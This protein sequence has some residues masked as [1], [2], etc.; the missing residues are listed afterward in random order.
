MEKEF[1]K[2][3]S[4]PGYIFNL[5]S[6]KECLNKLPNTKNLKILR[7]IGKIEKNCIQNSIKV[8]KSKS[9]TYLKIIKIL[10]SDTKCNFCIPSKTLN[11][12]E[13][14]VTNINVLTPIEIMRA[15]DEYY[16]I[17]MFQLN[18]LTKNSNNELRITTHNFFNSFIYNNIRNISKTGISPFAIAYTL[19]I[20][21][22]KS[23]TFRVK[24]LNNTYEALISLHLK[25]DIII[26]IKYKDLYKNVHSL[27]GRCSEYYNIENKILHNLDLVNINVNPWYWLGQEKE[28]SLE[29]LCQYSLEYCNKHSKTSPYK[30]S[31]H[32]LKSTKK[33]IRVQV[34]DTDTNNKC[35]SLFVVNKSYISDKK[36]VLSVYLFNNIN[37]VISN[38]IKDQIILKP[39]QLSSFDI[40]NKIILGKEGELEL[41]HEERY[42]R[43]EYNPKRTVSF[44]GK[45]F[46]QPYHPKLYSDKNK[47]FEL[48]RQLAPYQIAI[49]DR[50]ASTNQKSMLL[51][52][53]MGT[54]KTL[55]A[56]CVMYY[57]ATIR[58]PIFSFIVICPDSIK[59]FRSFRLG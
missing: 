49:V 21:Q 46:Y 47:H 9:I 59:I 5:K 39:Y 29:E 3:L 54:G 31:I 56:L 55:T 58:S 2:L 26:D 34:I 10:Q 18:N 16:F 30:V 15:V 25:S 38:V 6:V 7:F 11:I 53:Y 41:H 20:G 40:E 14:I 24:E 52:H 36:C 22:V 17:K 33:E 43:F 23:W 13:K 45:E 1:G 37:V 4:T 19:I 42:L 27:I 12:A 57:F 28:L 48:K 8:L 50:F 51:T 32:I 35:E 44:Y